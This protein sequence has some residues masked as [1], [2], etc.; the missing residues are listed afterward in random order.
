MIITIRSKWLLRLAWRRWDVPSYVT[1]RHSL[2]LMWLTQIPK[3]PK[4]VSK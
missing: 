1:A 3:Q 4:K 2:W